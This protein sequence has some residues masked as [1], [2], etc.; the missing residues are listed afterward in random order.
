MH[1]SAQATF[2]HANQNLL[3]VLDT[4]AGLQIAASPLEV[5]FVKLDAGSNII[6]VTPINFLIW[7]MEYLQVDMVDATTFHVTEFDD[8][9]VA[10]DL[11]GL[12]IF[13]GDSSTPLGNLLKALTVLKTSAPVVPASCKDTV[14]TVAAGSRTIH[15]PT[16]RYQ[17]LW[18]ANTFSA[19]GAIRA[20]QAGSVSTASAIPAK[21]PYYW[22]I[23]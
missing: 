12:N 20:T 11:V 9:V 5:D 1:S 2:S 22:S 10:S 13:D 7:P 4:E 23:S 14:Y 3:A 18:I 17:V 16:R 6:G 8:A 19:S 15:K 21:Y